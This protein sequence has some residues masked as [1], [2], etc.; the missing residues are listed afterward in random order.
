[1]MTKELTSLTPELI[2]KL[3]GSSSQK[4]A[5]KPGEE[6]RFAIVFKANELENAEFFTTRIF[7]VNY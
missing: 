4:M 7:S 1:M 2:E 5:V 3:Q 6:K